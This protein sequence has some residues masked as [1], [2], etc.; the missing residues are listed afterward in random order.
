M[1]NLQ[2]NCKLLTALLENNHI[3]LFRSSLSYL[4]FSFVVFLSQLKRWKESNRRVTKS[5]QKNQGTLHRFKLAHGEE[6]R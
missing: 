5:L 4:I 6:K 3:L 2:N 1:G